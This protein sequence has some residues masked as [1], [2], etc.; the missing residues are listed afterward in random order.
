V[1]EATL[2]ELLD[3]GLLRGFEG[4]MAERSGSFG[5]REAAALELANEL[6]RAWTHR[7]L[8]RIADR[9]EDEVLV[10]DQRYRR[11]ASGVRRYHS[12]CGSVAVRRDSYRLVGVHNGPTVVPLEIEAG[13]IENATPALAH[14]AIQAF[15]TMP[16]RHYEDEMR[17]AHRAIPSRST[18]E[19]VGKRIGAAVR[20]AL[21]VIEPIVRSR[22]V[23]PKQAHSISIGLDRTTMPMA[24]P[25]DDR[26][27]P[28]TE[29]HVRQRPPTITVA[30]RMAYVATVSVNDRQGEV[31][32]STRV[33]S[34]AAEGAT[35]MMERLGAELQHLLG[36]RPKLPVV[37]VQ[38]GAPELWNLVDEWLE[39]FRVRPAMNL[40]DR[41]HVDERLAQAAEA[42][43]RDESAR[44]QLIE[45]W[46]DR[47]DRS[48]LAIRRICKELDDKLYGPLP[49]DADDSWPLSRPRRLTGQNA[50]IVEGHLNYFER[51]RSKFC[52][53]TA[54]K[55]GFPIG[56]GPTEGAC[57]SVISARFKRSGQ[58]WFESGAS[59][60]LHLRT[61]HLNNRLSTSFQLFV[62]GRRRMIQ[63]S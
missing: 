20:E 36:Q 13:I 35:G 1:E 55:R 48:D 53:A 14:S 10:D 44:R 16:L 33:T 38:D 54:R 37:V 50:R 8:G 41:Y 51:N 40:I 19:R 31:V 45:K 6:V 26:R 12:L 60:C 32:T 2:K 24:E 18:L 59:P 4:V 57:K 5:E 61:L 22:E 3:T 21:P 27:Q 43:E 9:Y 34:T 63:S 56:S 62:D 52:Y 39:N 42:A 46:R 28:R 25:T 58:R 7:E 49:E 29:S 30:Y 11:H 15:A 47:L 23:V 17:A